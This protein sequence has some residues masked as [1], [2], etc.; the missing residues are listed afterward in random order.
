ME[1]FKDLADKG[2]LGH[3]GMK[4]SIAFI[5]R[6]IGWQL[7]SI[8]ETLEPV[9]SEEDIT[10]D[11]MDIKA[12]QATGIKNVGTGSYLGKELIRLDLRMYVGA[13]NPHDAIKVTGSPPVDMVVKNGFAGDEAT[14]AALVNSIP[15]VVKAPP[16][17]CTMMDLPV[18]RI[19]R[20]IANY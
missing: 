17:I 11:Y 10:T 19:F 14:V 7:D 8:E 4:E 20:G 16:G 13:K 1:Q 6:G 9:V 18:P 15:S 12:G 2:N 5:A 3:I